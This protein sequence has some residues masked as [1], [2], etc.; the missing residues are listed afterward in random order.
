LAHGR[1][2]RPRRTCCSEQLP[3]GRLRDRRE[4]QNTYMVAPS[5]KPRV[6]VALT[7]ILSLL[8]ATMVKPQTQPLR[9]DSVAWL[10]F[11][12]DLHISFADTGRLRKLVRTMLTDVVQ[13]GDVVAIRTTGSSAVLTDF[14]RNRELVT[15]VAE[16]TGSGLR[17]SE[18]AGTNQSV[19]LNEM[20]HR[21]HVS[22]SS[23]IGAVAILGQIESRHRGLLYISNGHPFDMTTFIE[24]R[25]LAR[26]AGQNG[27]KIFAID[28]RSLDTSPQPP[29]VSDPGSDDHIKATRN[30][31][32]VLSEQSGGFA[33]LDGD[34]M[35]PAL[36]RMIDAIRQ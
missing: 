10:V 17:P 33:I 20:Q 25:A 36:Q 24:A 32:R 15:V 1:Q 29:A 26:V 21:T 2:T 5:L 19:V 6:V 7:V 28:A 31:L 11:V 30:S 9:R 16:L 18:A 35:R 23:A 27:V 8:G 22:L 13:E 4:R 12:D 14:K 34:D 3:S